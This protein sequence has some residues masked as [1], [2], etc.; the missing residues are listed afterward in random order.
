MALEDDNYTPCANFQQFSDCELYTNIRKN[1]T[2]YPG[3][4]TE[5]T[6][7]T[8]SVLVTLQSIRPF[9]KVEQETN[10]RK[11]RQKGKNRL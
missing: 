3:Q 5:C 11:G 1:W 7:Y 8:P 4:T 10:K 9:V 6:Y 2:F